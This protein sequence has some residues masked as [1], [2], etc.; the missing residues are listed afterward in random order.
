MCGI[1]IQEVQLLIIKR[2]DM[3]CYGGVD[4]AMLWVVLWQLSVLNG[5]IIV[6]ARERMRRDLGS[7]SIWI[8]AR[9]L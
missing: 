8:M 9:M 4:I 3:Y 7:C 2:V 1:E 6:A 5:N